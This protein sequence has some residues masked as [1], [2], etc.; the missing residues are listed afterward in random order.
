MTGAP[1]PR[2]LLVVAPQCASMK[3]LVRLKEASSALH[4]ALADGELGDCA[5]G[6]PDGRSL[7]NG[8]RLTSN[9]IRTLVGDAIRHAADRRASLVLA[10]LGH[11]FVPGSTTTLHLMGADS[12]EEDTTDRAVNV[13]GLLAAAANNPAIP[14]VIGIIDTCHAA[15]A[16]PASQDLAAGASNGR[17]R[18]ALLMASSVNQSADDLRFSRALAELIRAGIPGAGALLGVDET[19]RSLRGTVV[20]QDVTGFLHDGDHFAR[21]PIWISRNAHHREVA[22]GGLRGPLADEE[23][24]AAFGALAGHGSVPALPFDVKSCLASLAELKG[25]VPSAAR[26]RAVVAV[27]C[28]LTALRTVE[29]LRGWL[30]ADLTTAGLRH[31]LR[32]LL[33]SEE[34]TLT[35]VPDTTDV[36]ILDQL[37]FDFPMSKGSCRPSVA[38]FVVRLSHAAGRDLAAPELHRWAHA[39]H[40]QQEVND[41]VARMLDSTEELPLRLVVGLDSSLTGGWPE[42]LSGWLLR[43]RDGKL[44]GRRDFACPSPDRRGTETAVEAAV[45][46]AESQA[47]ELE[48]PLRRLDIAAP[49]GLLIDWRPEEAGE[50]LRYGVQYDVVLHWS[51]RLVPD[52]LLRRL[53]S[54]VQD[55]WEAIAAYASG[56]PVDWLTQG[57]TE[58]RQSLRGHLRDGRYQRGIGLTQHA[59]LD[60]E[61]MDMLLSC[62]PVLLWPHVAEGFPAGRH[63]CLESHWMTLPEGLGHAYRRRWRGEDA[64]DVADLRAV[65]DDREWLRFCRLVR[66]TVPPVQTAIEEAS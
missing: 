41:A 14:S 30:G 44:L 3:R 47:E 29:F 27:D 7:I 45:T 37:T 56:V 25:Q 61:L 62:T 59:G 17:S 20:G 15:G 18:L 65:W 6:L 48:R 26:D 21:E 32:L 19:L 36:G 1:S 39:I 4:A 24:V 31:A 16:L 63:R 22:P 38:E 54:A 46:W 57:D 33:A 55:R 64:V 10:L 42:S 49:S 23:L 43:L 58:E 11:G 8:D 2:H 60:D 52:P 5:P 12:T 50:V 9:W 51:R 53:Q 13:G 28:L 40:A 35:T 66:T 34:R